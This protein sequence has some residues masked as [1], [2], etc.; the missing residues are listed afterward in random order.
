MKRSGLDRDYFVKRRGLLLISGLYGLVVV[1]VCMLIP[2]SL[3]MQMLGFQIALWGGFA[4]LSAPFPI[5]TVVGRLWWACYLCL[6]GSAA[7]AIVFGI[8]NLF[9]WLCALLFTVVC[10]LCVCLRYQPPDK[11]FLQ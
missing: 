11:R 4:L 3:W 6:L 5:K 7:G 1:I 2:K 8:H 9:G 10:A